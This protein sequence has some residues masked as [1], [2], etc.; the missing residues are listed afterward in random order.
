[1]LDEL[2]KIERVIFQ[3]PILDKNDFPPLDS[4]EHERIKLEKWM[5]DLRY[6]ENVCYA[7]VRENDKGWFIDVYFFMA[8]S[9]NGEE[10]RFVIAPG[11]EMSEDE[12]E[13]FLKD[14]PAR[15]RILMTECV[16]V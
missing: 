9:I 8:K 6:D 13:R 5:F 2:R 14:W 10:E 11:Y 16:L 1:M 4:E 15:L 7:Y 12:E 3:N